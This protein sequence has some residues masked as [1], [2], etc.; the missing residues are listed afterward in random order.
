MA[1]LPKIEYNYYTFNPTSPDSAGLKYQILGI[2]SY[3]YKLK[4]N[5]EISICSPNDK[6]PLG[7][8]RAILNLYWTA[9]VVAG[10]AC[11]LAT[12]AM[13]GWYLLSNLMVL[14]AVATVA[15][16]SRLIVYL[17]RQLKNKSFEIANKVICTHQNRDRLFNRSEYPL[18]QA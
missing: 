18:A 7:W 3:E 14:T 1:S 5:G 15:I 6:F 12:L 11:A 9:D 17:E 16:T 10:V 8:D 2:S 13:A 4:C